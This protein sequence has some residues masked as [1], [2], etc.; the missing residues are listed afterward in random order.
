MGRIAGKMT[1]TNIVGHIA[2]FPIPEIISGINAF[3]RGMMATIDDLLKS[4]QIALN[5]GNPNVILCE[6][7]IR[8]FD[9][10]LRNTFSSTATPWRSCSTGRFAATGGETSGAAEEAGEKTA[11]AAS[12]SGVICCL[13]RARRRSRDAARIVRVRPLY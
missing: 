9:S 2:S 5:T 3:E 11:A 8:T 4:A 6:R 13:A 1:K 7:G 12:G 10:T